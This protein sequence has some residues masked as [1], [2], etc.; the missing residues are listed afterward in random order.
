[1]R[2]DMGTERGCPEAGPG[3]ADKP[4]RSWYAH[5][6]LA[7]W[8]LKA[9]WALLIKRYAINTADAL[10]AWA[11]RQDQQ[12]KPGKR[13]PPQ[14]FAGQEKEGRA[15]LGAGSRTGAVMLWHSAVEPSSRPLQL[16]CQSVRASF[17]YA[18]LAR[19]NCCQHA[20]GITA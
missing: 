1:M 15:L 5:T 20:H 4:Q 14:H 16:A 10:A 13:W 11:P 18:V 19:L 6:C 17:A 9:E 12:P 8:S 3:N 2:Q 7:C